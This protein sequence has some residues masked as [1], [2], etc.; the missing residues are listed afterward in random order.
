MKH[1]LFCVLSFVFASPAFS[2]ITFTA[3]YSLEGASEGFNDPAVGAQRKAAFEYTLGLVGSYFS[4]RYAGETVVVRAKF[5]PLGGTATSAALAGA[6]AVSF[7]RDFSGAPLSNTFYPRA[8]AN[9]LFGSDGNGSTPEIDITFNSDV[10]NAAVMGTKSWY[11]GTDRSPGTDVDMVTAGIH[12]IGHGLGFHSLLA[13]T[14]GAYTSGFPTIWDR[15]LNTSITGGTKLPN[16]ASDTLR[17][18]EITASDLWWDGPSG[19]AA[20]GG[21]RPRIY[22]PTIFAAGSSLSHLSE[23]THPFDLMSP[24]DGGPVNYS[25]MDLGIFQDMGWTLVPEPSG[26]VLSGMAICAVLVRRRHR[27]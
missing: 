17:K 27:A 20:N 26:F 1:T 22:A 23:S 18:N 6:S 2:G 19:T 4:P 25:T 11:Y 5:D 24:V 7:N 8:L 21:V 15:F 14:T 3:D 9:H 12:E 13:S 10:D 16:L